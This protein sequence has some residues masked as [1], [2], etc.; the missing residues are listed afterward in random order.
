MPRTQDRIDRLNKIKSEINSYIN[1]SEGSSIDTIGVITQKIDILQ[2]VAFLVK[3][4]Q[5][6]DTNSDIF[7]KIFKLVQALK[8]I[9]GTSTLTL[10]YEKVRLLRRHIEF[11]ADI[12]RNE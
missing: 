2:D 5:I 1:L 3:D 8:E 10:I 7:D 4:Y 6:T 11:L 9:K 12:D